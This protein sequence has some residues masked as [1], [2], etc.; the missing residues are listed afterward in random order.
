MAYKLAKLGTAAL[1][2]LVEVGQHSALRRSHFPERGKCPGLQR[3]KGENAH[4]YLRSFAFGVQLLEAS[5]SSTKVPPSSATSPTCKGS[6]VSQQRGKKQGLGLV[7]PISL[8]WS[9]Y[10]TSLSHRFLPWQTGRCICV[11]PSFVAVDMVAR[12]QGLGLLI[13]V[14]AVLTYSHFWKQSIFEKEVRGFVLHS[15]D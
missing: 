12:A 4:L 1:C 13:L 15:F 8:P 7:L 14:P 10:L 5:V 6:G 2:P 11:S 9:S 3:A